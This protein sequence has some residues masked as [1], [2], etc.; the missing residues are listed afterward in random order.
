MAISIFISCST[1]D[2]VSS[3]VDSSIVGVEQGFV[4][5]GN[6]SAGIFALYVE[7]LPEASG[8]T[9]PSLDLS[10]GT[11][12]FEFFPTAIYDHAMYL[13]RTDGQPGFAKMVVD[14]LGE[15]REVGV[16]PTSDPQ[17]LPSFRIGVQNENTGVYQDRSQPNTITVFDPATLI[18]TGEID[19]SEAPEP[20]T[21]VESRYQRFIFRGDEAFMPTRGNINGETYTSFNLQVASLASNS[22][23]GVTSVD[24]PNGGEILTVNNFG[25]GLVDTNGDLYVADGGVLAGSPARIYR[26]PA[27]SNEI[28]ESYN[29]SPVFD[30][31]PDNIFYPTMNS[32]KLVAP[33]I[34]IAKVNTDVPTAVLQ[35]VFSYPGETQEEQFNNFIQDEAAVSRVFALLFTSVTAIW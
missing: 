19:M 2:G 18:V 10:D 31:A 9:V 15:F 35:I 17:G 29:Y 28:D 8:E 25:Q 6:S 33:G 14:T 30:L 5:T 26:I 32:F 1:D 13:Q 27:G 24:D 11:D 3:N 7:E 16:L 12:F 21:D 20:I 22:Y 34:A 23:A 4:F